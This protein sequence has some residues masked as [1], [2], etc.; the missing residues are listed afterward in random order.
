MSRSDYHHLYNTAAWK[1]ARA[2]QLSEHPLCRM[3]LE[4]G[5]TVPATVADHIRPHKGDVELFFGRGNLQS[6]CKTCHDSHKQAQEHN[7]DGVLRGAGLTGRPLDLAHPWHRPLP[8]PQGGGE[9]S[10][11]TE[12]QTGRF[13][14]FAG[15]HN[16]RGG[17][18]A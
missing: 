6:L 9:K 12:D 16:G 1:R 17:L 7:A 4:L 8:A 3:H 11:P 18:S 2:A 15:C 5:R 10:S 14:S 13:P